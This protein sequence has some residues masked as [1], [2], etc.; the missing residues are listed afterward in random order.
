MI[1]SLLVAMSLPGWA[2]AARFD[3]PLCG[4]LVVTENDVN[5]TFSFSAR[6]A[7]VK[8]E[9]DDQYVVRWNPATVFYQKEG[10]WYLERANALAWVRWDPSPDMVVGIHGLIRGGASETLPPELINGYWQ[11]VT[12]YRNPDRS[13]TTIWTD[14]VT[15][16][17]TQIRV[18]GYEPKTE[19]RFLNVTT[20]NPNWEFP[21]AKPYKDPR[22]LPSVLDRPNQSSPPY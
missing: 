10:E 3:E 22:D 14:K 8:L 5:K 19:V 2:G 7:G 4:Q 11:D 20:C 15:H 6:P 21:D 1:A 13:T 17:P 18:E 16:F 9:G 12:R